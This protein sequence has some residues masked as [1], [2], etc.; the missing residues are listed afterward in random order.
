[1]PRVL[2]IVTTAG[3]AGVER[4]VCNVATETAKRGWEATVVGGERERMQELLDGHA[5]WEPGATPLEAVRSVRRLGRFD[6]CHVHMTAAEAV[7]L[8]TRPVHRAPIVSTR[9]FAAHRGA[10]ALGH[11][12]AP[13]IGARMAR[14]I[15]IGE[16]VAE[17]LE[18][19][20]DAV[21]VTGVPE[22][23]CL[24]QPAS[25]TV[26]VLQRLEAEKDTMTALRAWQM[27]EL[28]GEG[29]SLSVFG[30]GSQRSELEHWVTAEGVAG[31]NFGGWTNDTAGELSRAGILLASAVAEP[32]GLS[33][34]DAM[35]AGVPVVASSGGG[36]LETIGLVDEAPRFPP[37]DAAA[38]ASALR[39]MRSDAL[40][41]RLSE[42]GRRIVAERFAI[43]GYIDRLLL[44]YDAALGAAP[45]GRA[46]PLTEG[47]R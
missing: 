21:I 18:R 46:E 14:Q 29:W 27:S 35:A 43:D 34:L 11:L 32:L 12:A 16:F 41:A 38:A 4:Y 36:H 37:G 20:P 8:L 28:A 40:R 15:A 10:S 23:R 33:V 19:R 44:E 7:A 9:H 22:V 6:I 2:H 26:L 24:W 13:W 30:A 1:M 17:H 45:Q 47:V 39:S 25:R 31:V 3:F 5:D 42:A